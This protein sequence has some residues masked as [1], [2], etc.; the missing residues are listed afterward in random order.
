MLELFDS[1]FDKK[2][3]SEID[4]KYVKAFDVFLQKRECKGNTRKYYFKALR[5]ILNKAIQDQEAS[6]VTYPLEK[7]VLI[8]LPWKKKQQSAICHMKIWIN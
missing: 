4:I 6:E 8:S 2:V 3:F 7:E 5:A 1:K